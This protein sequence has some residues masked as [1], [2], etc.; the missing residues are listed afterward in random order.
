MQRNSRLKYQSMPTD[1]ALCP[2]L[3]R[4]W[5]ENSVTNAHYNVNRCTP[6]GGKGNEYEIKVITCEHARIKMF[7][8]G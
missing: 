8:T 2:T 7:I 1:N 6:L 3:L 5:V 4:G